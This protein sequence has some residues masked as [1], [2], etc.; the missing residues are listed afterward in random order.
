VRGR[1]LCY[2]LYIVCLSSFVPFLRVRIGSVL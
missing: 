1:T 2:K